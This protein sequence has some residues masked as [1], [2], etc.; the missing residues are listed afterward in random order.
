MKGTFWRI[1]SPKR[2]NN[3][4]SWKTFFLYKQQLLSHIRMERKRFNKLNGQTFTENPTRDQE[5]K[6]LARGQRGGLV[7]VDCFV[8][9]IDITGSAQP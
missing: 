6:E 9:K 5:N 3:C 1:L 4:A 2:T 8:L 7:I